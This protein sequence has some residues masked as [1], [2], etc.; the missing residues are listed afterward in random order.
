MERRAVVEDFTV[1]QH[2]VRQRRFK[3]KHLALATA[4]PAPPP[5][6]TLRP[7]PPLAVAAGRMIA[8]DEAGLVLQFVQD[9][10]WVY[11]T[12]DGVS[13]VSLPAQDQDQDHGHGHGH[14]PGHRVGEAVDESWKKY[15]PSF[16]SNKPV[17]DGS[18]ACLPE[19]ERT[20]SILAGMLYTHTHTYTIYLLYA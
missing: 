16:A 19:I 3:F 6:D 12:P 15:Q 2:G 7:D 20:L 13:D 18:T 11:G 1:D 5:S 17:M 10:G 9:V 4:P 8:V 14:E